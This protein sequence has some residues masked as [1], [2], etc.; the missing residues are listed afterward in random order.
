MECYTKKSEILL[1]ASSWMKL[2]DIMIIKR[3]QTLKSSYCMIS[4]HVKL[5]NRKN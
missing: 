2:T 1:H 4:M 5:K 3:S